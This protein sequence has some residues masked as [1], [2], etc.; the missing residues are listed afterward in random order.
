MKLSEIG[1]EFGFIERIRGPHAGAK[2]QGLV[3]PMGD[4]AAVLDVPVGQQ[5][6]V[7]T[8]MLL[9]GVHFQ[10]EWSDA[11]SIGWKAAAANLSDLAAMGAE[12]AYAFVALGISPDD[13]VETLERLYDGFTDCLN[14]YGARL[15][16]GDTNASLSGLVVAVTA[17]GTV[18]AGKALTRAGARPG[19]ALLVTGTLGDAAA[20]LFL[21][22][23]LGTAK[24]ERAHRDLVNAHRRPPPR[25]PAG[26]AAA[27]TGLVHAAIDLSDGLGGD[28]MKLCA[29]SGVGARIDAAKLPISEAMRAAAQEHGKDPVELALSGGEDYEL[30][31]AVPATGVEAVQNAMQDVGVA[32]TIIGEVARSGVRLQGL[33]GTETDLSEANFGWNHLSA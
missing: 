10:K 20:G 3:V 32:S 31:L 33:D 11:Y 25:I 6:V 29:A 17:F 1:G 19:D 23:K 21:L 30:L 22:E 5:I 16:G 27:A 24:A 28:L 18:E 4:D 15:A 12:P 7:T 14:R 9:E 26:R 8:D 13:T 2:G